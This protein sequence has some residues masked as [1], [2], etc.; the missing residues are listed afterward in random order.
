MTLVSHPRVRHTLPT[1]GTEVMPGNGRPF[2]ARS[3]RQVGPRMSL[4]RRLAGEVVKERHF[5]RD[6]VAPREGSGQ[7]CPSYSARDQDLQAEPA[8]GIGEA[9]V[10]GDEGTEIPTE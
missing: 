1:A 10:V 5:C 7:E 6:G 2:E 4:V 8:C 9:F 3:K